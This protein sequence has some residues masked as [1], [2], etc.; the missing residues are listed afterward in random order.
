MMAS[1]LVFIMSVHGFSSTNEIPLAFIGYD[2]NY[3]LDNVQL[4]HEGGELEILYVVAIDEQI[5]TKMH[6][7]Y[8]WK[9]KVAWKLHYHN[10]PTWAFFKVNNNQPVNLFQN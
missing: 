1:C 5:V 3:N 8:L 7:E 9:Q 6:L 10:S 4:T 2:N